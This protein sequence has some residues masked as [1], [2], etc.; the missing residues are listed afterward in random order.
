MP[1]LTISLSVRDMGD[2]IDTM[3]Q[4]IA[5]ADECEAGYVP[6]SEAAERLRVI[7]KDWDES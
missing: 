6:A 4:L 3:E 7:L 5:L 1:E 2:W